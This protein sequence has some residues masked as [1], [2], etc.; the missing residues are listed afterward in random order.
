MQQ[1]K[2]K[3]DETIRG[4][5][6]GVEHLNPVTENDPKKD[7]KI[8]QL[9]VEIES[10]KREK[11]NMTRQMMD[12]LNVLESILQDEKEEHLKNKTKLRQTQESLKFERQKRIQN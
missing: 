4:R 7:D 6:V 11:E 10:M 8:R 12:K 5:G 2:E 3:F 1:P 9:Q